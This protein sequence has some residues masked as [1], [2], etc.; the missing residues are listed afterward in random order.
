LG[1]KAGIQFFFEGIYLITIRIGCQHAGKW[2]F[3]EEMNFRTKLFFQTTNN[4]GGQD[5]IPNGG[6]TEYQDLQNKY[7]RIMLKKPAA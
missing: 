6:K 1:H 4:R 7:Q 3:G 2:L 5:N